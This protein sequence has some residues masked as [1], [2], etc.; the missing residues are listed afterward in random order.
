EQDVAGVLGLDAGALEVG[1]QVA[2]AVDGDDGAVHGLVVRHRGGQGAGEWRGGRPER[3]ELERAAGEPGGERRKD[4]ATVE[5]GAGRG[6]RASRESCG[7]STATARA[8]SLASRRSGSRPL[9]GARKIWP[10]ASR[11]TMPRALPTPGSTTATCTLPGGNQAYDRASQNAASATACGGM[12]WVRSMTRA[13]G[14]RAAIT[15]F[16]MPTNGSLSPKS[17]SRVMTPGRGA[18]GRSVIG[19]GGV[20]SG[21]AGGRLAPA[22]EA[23]RPAL[24]GVGAPRGAQ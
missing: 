20:R 3:G 7:R 16:M 21:G 23:A 18:R 5:G 4:V 22:G 15:P 9:S 11:A 14:K 19:A 10:Q 13:S 2:E 1:D 24:L 12:P 17:V 8:P 6:G